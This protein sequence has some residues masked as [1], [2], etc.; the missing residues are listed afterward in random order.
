MQLTR[1]MVPTSKY[2]IKCPYTMVAEG[3]A[4]HN[5]AN[6]A[7]AMSEISYMVGNNNKV[8][9]HCA[10][11]DYRIVQGVEFDRNTW[12]AG[13]GTNGRG[14][15]KMI[16]IEI[17][18]STNPDNSMFDK[19]EKLA[20][21]YIAYL[22]KQNNWGIDRVYKHQDFS[23]KYCPHKTLD[24][25][26]E[27]FL[28]LIRAELGKTTSTVPVP[29]V[30]NSNGYLVKV[31]ATAL[32]IRSGAGTNNSI[33]GCIRDKGTYTIVET[34]GNWGKLKSGL[35]WI[36]LD[37][38]QKVGTV[39]NSAP[40]AQVTSF[41]KGQRVTLKTSA[42]KY[43]TGQTIPNSIKGKTYTIMQVGSGN[44][45]PDGV[46]LKEIYSWVYKADIQ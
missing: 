14:N 45:H 2:N 1:L 27:R 15:R 10:V 3:I 24:L 44:T 9:Y 28:N 8:S 12:N 5:T 23:G 33:V 7:S 38:T 6:K 34:S 43:C 17:C 37:Y 21:K 26:W 29:N 46:L 16:A 22:L 19:A 35:G 25:G 41:S 40:A 32:N 39:K 36:C 30:T 13:D 31:T 11:D 4:V 42:S 20:A 18:H